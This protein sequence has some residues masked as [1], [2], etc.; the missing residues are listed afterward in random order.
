MNPTT[1]CTNLKC[2]A[3][4]SFPYLLFW[5]FSFL[6]WAFWVS[7]CLVV[8]AAEQRNRHPAHFG[9]IAERHRRAAVQGRTPAG[10]VCYAI[11]LCAGLVFHEKLV[12]NFAYRIELSWWMFAAGAGLTFVIAWLT[13][14]FQSIKAATADPVESLRSE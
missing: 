12:E 14:S 3:G 4:S 8:G 13:V 5:P 11:G 1:N 2:A 6:V 10:A 7:G 9:R